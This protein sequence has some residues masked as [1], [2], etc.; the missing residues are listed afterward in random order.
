M[1]VLKNALNEKQKELLRASENN[2]ERNLEILRNE[3]AS[4]DKTLDQIAVVKRGIEG[5]LKKEDLAVL[6]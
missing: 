2:L 3:A 6:Q 1:A 4:A 5:T